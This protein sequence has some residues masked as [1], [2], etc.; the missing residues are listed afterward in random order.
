MGSWPE[1]AAGWIVARVRDWGYG[2]I[3]TMM[4][5]ESSFVPFPSEVVLPPAG[6]LA[7][8]GQMNAWVAV[9]AGLLGSVLGALFNYFIA[10][11]VGEPF[12]RKH[13]R[14][15]FVTNDKLDRAE[16]F[17]RRHGEIGTFMGRLVPVVRQLISVPAGIARMNLARFIGFTA[18]GAGIWS[19][20]L[21]YIGLL[22]G[23]HEETLRVAAVHAYTKRAMLYLL[24]LM[25]LML[26]VYV[27]W[28]RRRR[29]P[30]A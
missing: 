24:P 23:R 30:S 10:V 20:I 17:F 19:G 25:A 7:A 22:L 14:Y 21:V 11:W 12:L 16:A 5:V 6:Y 27:F 15:F 3:F 1:L 18:L 8:K 29:A 13:G 4:F 26:A 2:G 9:G 28:Y